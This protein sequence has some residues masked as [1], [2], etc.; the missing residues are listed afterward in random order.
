MHQVH[1]LSTFHGPHLHM[2]HPKLALFPH[3]SSHPT[4][5]GTSIC[6]LA[7]MSPLFA[8]AID[9]GPLDPTLELSISLLLCARR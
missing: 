1:R 9:P 6:S 4:F 5:S 7:L 8:E 2:I 3:V